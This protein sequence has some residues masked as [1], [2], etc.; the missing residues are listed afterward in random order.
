MSLYCKVCARMPIELINKAIEEAKEKLAAEEVDKSDMKS[1]AR[2]L[3]AVIKDI[4]LK[5][6]I[7]LD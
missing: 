3:K 6:N 2:I 4:A 7:D 1:K 5:V